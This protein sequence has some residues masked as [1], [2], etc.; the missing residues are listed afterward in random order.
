MGLHHNPYLSSGAKP[1]FRRGGEVG[2]LCIHGFSAAPTEISWLADHLHETLNMT[3]YTPR[4]AGHGTDYRAMHR[5]HWHDWYMSARDGYQL[6]QDQCDTVYIAGISMGGL[7]ALMLTSAAD[8]DPAATAVIASPTHF[9]S[10]GVDQA[11]W[12]RFFRRFAHLPDRTDVP[13]IVREEQQRR[14]EPIVG[15]THYSTWAVSAVAQMSLL[16]EAVREN[17]YQI[18]T[19]LALIY[20]EHDHAVPL[21]CM[22]FIEAHVK[23]ETVERLVLHRSRHLVTQ[24][25]ERD[26]AFQFIETFFERT[27]AHAVSL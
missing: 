3:T 20:A 24:D 16:A 27:P 5:M 23:S 21:S 9:T 12:M 26:T 10:P 19:P 8:T 11:R 17:L 25:V 18:D 6:L 2:C 22:D 13:Q 1:I 4:L 14:G 15:R 7:L